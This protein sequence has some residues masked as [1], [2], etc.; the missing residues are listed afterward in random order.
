MCHGIFFLLIKTG[1]IFNWLFS[2]SSQRIEF[3]P[4]TFLKWSI[5]L[6]HWFSIMHC[7]RVKCTLHIVHKIQSCLD[8]IRNVINTNCLAF[9]TC[10]CIFYMKVA[11]VMLQSMLNAHC[12]VQ[13]EKRNNFDSLWKLLLSAEIFSS[14]CCILPPSTIPN[15]SKHTDGFISSEYRSL[16]FFLMQN[17][18]SMKCFVPCFMCPMRKLFREKKPSRRTFLS[19]R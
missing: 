10:C 9:Q 3:P 13:T 8:S 2:K 14:F 12:I 16:E 15:S 7:N 1:H 17:K 19:E 5:P 6:T 18:L 4:D 11:S